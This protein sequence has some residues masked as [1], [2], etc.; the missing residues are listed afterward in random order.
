MDSIAGFTLLLRT[1]IG[2]ALVCGLAYLILRY[3]LPRMKIQTPQGELIRV[4]E[5]IHLD[6]S[7]T[8]SVIDVCGKYYLITTSPNSSNLIAELDSKK[9][10]EAE[11]EI[12]QKMLHQREEK[13]EIW[14]NILS[15]F[16]NVL[17]KKD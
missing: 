7:Q 13:K 6:A 12:N 15:K 8:L 14:Q 10:G 1:L 11:V 3:I 5:K 2:L 17:N 4:V 16:S 9:V